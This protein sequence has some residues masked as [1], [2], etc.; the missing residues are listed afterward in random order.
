MQTA[1]PLV[2]WRVLRRRAWQLGAETATPKV[3]HLDPP[4]TLCLKPIRVRLAVE[5]GSRQRSG[6]LSL[7]LIDHTWNFGEQ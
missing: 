1:P 5:D 6:A 2:L 7:S 3:Q 4:P